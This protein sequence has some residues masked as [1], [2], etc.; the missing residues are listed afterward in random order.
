MKVTPGK[1]Y[2]D[3]EPESDA[4]AQLGHSGEAEIDAQVH[5]RSL[6]LTSAETRAEGMA[7][8]NWWLAARRLRTNVFRPGLFS[9]PAWDILLDLYTAE[10]RGERVKI[11]SLIGATAIP[12][13]TIIRWARIMT[14]EGLLV[15][16]K[17][18]RDG[19]RIYV[20]LSPE[21]R[22]LMEA[23]FETLGARATFPTSELR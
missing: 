15:R 3:K 23:Y 10:D 21:A 5:R 17:D 14:Q 9:D 18:P 11:T 13:S 20:R 1:P 7:V 22:D 12:H 8:A 6:K 2:R 16:Q 19:R 4:V